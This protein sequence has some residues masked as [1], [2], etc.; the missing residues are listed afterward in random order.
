MQIFVKDLNG[1]SIP[2]HI[3]QG[4]TIQEFKQEFGKFSQQDMTNVRLIW[5]SQELQ[6]YRA[7]NSYGISANTTL[8]SAV[9]VPG[10]Y[11]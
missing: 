10:G 5:G 9:R 3:R 11:C 8:H 7:M 6:D 2:Y 1:R 4:I